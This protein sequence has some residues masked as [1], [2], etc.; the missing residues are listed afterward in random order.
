MKSAAPKKIPAFLLVFLIL[1]LLKLAI[2]FLS[3]IGWVTP[4]SFLFIER[5][6]KLGTPEFFTTGGTFPL[7]SLL[8]YPALLLPDGFMVARAFMVIDALISSLLF[9]PIFLFAKKFMDELEAAEIALIACLL[10]GVLTCGQLIMA[11]NVFIPLLALSVYLT[12][13][14]FTRKSTKLD[15]ASGVVAFLTFSTKVLGSAVILLQACLIVNEIR[16]EGAVQTIKKRKGY[17]VLLALLAVFSLLSATNSA[18]K[19]A[20][21]AAGLAHGID[22]VSVLQVLLNQTIYLMFSSLVVFLPAVVLLFLERKSK[23]EQMAAGMVLFLCVVFLVSSALAVSKLPPILGGIY[24]RYLDPLAPLIF[25]I[26]YAWIK[27]RTKPSWLISGATL[28]FISLLVML[29]IPADLIGQPALALLKSHPAP[30]VLLASLL[31]LLLAFLS[32]SRHF[33]TA[34]IATILIFSFISVALLSA[35]RDLESLE[36]ALKVAVANSGPGKPVL[37]DIRPDEQIFSR[38]REDKHKLV[39]GITN[40]YSKGNVQ[41]YANQTNGPLVSVLPFAFK[42]LF[43]SSYF[44]VYEV[45]QPARLPDELPSNETFCFSSGL[46][47]ERPDNEGILAQASSKILLWADAGNK[48]VSIASA[49]GKQNVSLLSHGFNKTFEASETWTEIQLPREQAGTME[50]EIFGSASM[51]DCFGFECDNASI[52]LGRIR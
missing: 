7:Y 38:F 11:E 2:A 9:F 20:D 29:P 42:P 43:C 16:N 8:L 31:F 32:G 46:L 25:I 40:V 33:K 34:L 52:V 13:E 23:S 15:I 22:F 41:D 35:A 21:R 18:T 10:P 3:T 5:A 6:E 37:I 1:L 19:V 47:W 27:N 36:P 14:S 24:G 44:R 48:T 30:I 45:S 28:L 49:A 12:Y 51:R 50:I 17:L 26:G 4:D 39:L